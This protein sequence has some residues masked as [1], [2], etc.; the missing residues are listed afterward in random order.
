MQPSHKVE[1]SLPMDLPCLT[2]NNGSL[3]LV[4]GHQGCRCFSA[5]KA[6]AARVNNGRQLVLR[7]CY[8]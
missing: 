1:E 5:K 2:I 8:Y 3:F 6:K 4:G 7:N